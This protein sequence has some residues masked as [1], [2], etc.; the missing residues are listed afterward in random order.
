MIPNIFRSSANPVRHRHVVNKIVATSPQ[1]LYAVITDVDSYKHFLPFCKSSKVLRRSSC[2][3]QFDASLTIG[4]SNLPPLNAIKEEY[5]SRVRHVQQV[6]SDGK[7]EWM[8][9]AKSIRSNLFHGLNSSWHLTTHS[10]LLNSDTPGL[11]DEDCANDENKMTKVKFEVEMSV[12][13][14]MI[15][16]A[17]ENI[18]EN[19]AIRQI[20]AFE[21][22]CK[23]IP[24]NVKKEK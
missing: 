9:E 4:V 20:E 17:M 14:P 1:H 23:E 21:K 18:L 10:G 8:V 2:G 19:V 11:V 12:A 3:T 22:R 13:D 15:S 5:I 16:I 6:S 24:F 7:D